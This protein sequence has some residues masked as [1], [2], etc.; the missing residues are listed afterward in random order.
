MHL[1]LFIGSDEEEYSD[2]TSGTPATK[3]KYTYKR[4]F[5]CD[6]C[7]LHL[8]SKQRLLEHLLRHVKY[9][10][11]IC[12]ER[13]VH[14]IYF[15]S[16]LHNLESTI[17]QNN[18][19]M[20]MFI[21]L[22]VSAEDHWKHTIKPIIVQVCVLFVIVLTTKI[23]I[24]KISR[25]YCPVK[26]LLKKQENNWTSYSQSSPKFRVIYKLKRLWQ[27]MQIQYVIIARNHYTE[28]HL[29]MLFYIMNKNIIP[30]DIS[31]VVK[32]H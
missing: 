18:R 7:G 29:K 15:S 25:R 4:E 17:F 12:S 3:K 9:M 10:C 5:I 32:L 19:C 16:L 23:V 24:D 21:T 11:Q 27:N 20:F 31:N 26:M 8:S 2:K 6:S 13:Y 14:L 30:V 28:H 22:G 1:I